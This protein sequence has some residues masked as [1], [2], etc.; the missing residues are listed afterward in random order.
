[1]D[2]PCHA[3]VID[4]KAGFIRGLATHPDFRQV[5]ARQSRSQENEP[6][7][8]DWVEVDGRGNMLDH[9]IEQ[10]LEFE[11][12]LA[13]FREQSFV[14]DECLDLL[15]ALRDDE[16]Q[17]AIFERAGFQ[18]EWL[19]DLDHQRRVLD[20]MNNVL[21]DWQTVDDQLTERRT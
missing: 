21:L 6:V 7:V 14:F 2:E 11:T 5:S 20:E 9:Q 17:K 3:P 10:T 15:T 1:M 16:D 4:R 13:R 12:A 19:E 18:R 8:E